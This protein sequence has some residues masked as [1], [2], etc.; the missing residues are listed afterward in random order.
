MSGHLGYWD[1][2]PKVSVAALSLQNQRV[3]KEEDLIFRFS[4]VSEKSQKLMIDYRIY[5]MKSNGKQ[6][7]K[8]FKWADRTVKAGDV[9]E[10]PRK[11]SFKTISTRKHYPGRH[12]IEI[13]VNGQAMAES[14][15]ECD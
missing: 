6:A 1:M 7:P 11:Q 15:F 10:I 14:D 5:Y 3:L 13:I 4:L 9:V 2:S 12:K 8:T